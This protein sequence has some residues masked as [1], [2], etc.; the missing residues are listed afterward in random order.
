MSYRILSALA[1]LIL[2]PS[3]SHASLLF[4]VQQIDTSEIN[5]TVT[6]SV[7]APLA[8]EGGSL[9][10]LTDIFSSLMRGSA[11]LSN[12]SVVSNQ[13]STLTSAGAYSVSNAGLK[14]LMLGF[15]E[16]HIPG[17]LISG[18]VDITLPG[19]NLLRSVGSTGA[20]WYGIDD[21]NSLV[22]QTGSWE[23]VGQSVSLPPVLPLLVV[24]LFGVLGQRLAKP[25]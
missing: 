23:I 21:G 9:I 25:S 1:A 5:V 13:P 11:S 4:T 18:S 10:F 19:G 8:R 20:V 14:S 22:T 24:G 3:M 16:S 15:D 6:G 17:D 7:D 2:L 12:N